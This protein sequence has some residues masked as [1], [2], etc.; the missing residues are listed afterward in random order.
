M[1]GIHRCDDQHDTHSCYLVLSAAK[2]MR[3]PLLSVCAD[4][5]YACTAGPHGFQTRLTLY[6]SGE[7]QEDLYFRKQNVISS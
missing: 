5:Q 7:A 2:A 6:I 1:A 4:S 3:K